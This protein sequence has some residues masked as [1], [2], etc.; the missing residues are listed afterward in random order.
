MTRRQASA[1]LHDALGYLGEAG[2]R[3]WVRLTGRRLAKDDAHWL[4]CPTGEAG[5]VGQE[6]YDLLA[7]RE[8]L[9]VHRRPGAGL[10]EDFTALAGPHF[11]P[12]SVHPAIRAFYERTATYRMESWSEA[13]FLG[14]LPLWLLVTFVSRRMDQLNVPVSSL[15]LAGGMRSE[16]LELLDA[17]SGKRRYTGWLRT[18]TATGRVIYAGLYTTERVPNWDGPCVKV[19]FPLPLGCVI[20][21]LRPEAGPDGSFK[22]ISSGTRFGDPGFYRIVERRDRTRQVRYVR[23]LRE[24]FHL[25]IDREGI[26]R[27]DHTIR[28]TGINVLRMHYKIMPVAG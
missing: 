22:L 14:R 2:I 20:G 5:R 24:F 19:S 7:R 28:F 27:T 8:G 10:L 1:G 13:G 6:V 4:S 21:F 12:S 9:L 15:E 26:L 25:Y 23:P 17:S 3:L 16:V 11:D 18:M